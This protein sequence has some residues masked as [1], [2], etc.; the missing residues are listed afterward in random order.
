[1]NILAH[2]LRSVISDL[3]A[4]GSDTMTATLAWIV[5]YLLNYPQVQQKLQ[6]ELDA[7]VGA[8]RSPTLNDRKRQ[9]LASYITSTMMFDIFMRKLHCRLPYTECVIMEVMRCSS[10]VPVGVS[11]TSLEDTK[12]GGY[13]I[14]KGTL[15]FANL[16][17]VHHDPE[18]W[19]EPDEFR[20]ERFLN[21][22][23]SCMQ[24]HESLMPFGAGR[25]IC[26]GEHLARDTL[27]LFT[28]TMFQ[29]FTAIVPAGYERPTLETMPGQIT[30][31][32]NKFHVCMKYR[33]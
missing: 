17:Q 3:F 18:V 10:I 7:V 6:L 23:G 33:H 8:E 2:S 26:M 29:K 21:P 13:D 16:Y 27:F 15:V 4:A 5:L 30:V 32:P 31:Q 25:R 28:S 12:L 11:H 19:G 9:D 20:P 1:M 14:P 24:R 22:D